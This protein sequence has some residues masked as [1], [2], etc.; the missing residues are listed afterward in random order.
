MQAINSIFANIIRFQKF[1]PGVE[2]P[3]SAIPSLSFP[4]T[5]KPPI[6]PHH[7]NWSITLLD[8][9]QI[10]GHACKD[11]T[12][13]STYGRE[14]LVPRL[15]LLYPRDLPASQWQ[16]NKDDCS[17]ICRLQCTYTIPLSDRNPRLFVMLGS[18][19]LNTYRV[20]PGAVFHSIHTL[21]M[22]RTRSTIFQT[23][24]ANMLPKPNPIVQSF[25]DLVVLIIFTIQN[26]QT[27]NKN[28]SITIDERFRLLLPIQYTLFLG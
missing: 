23:A 12:S 3:D 26:N 6:C 1:Y 7:S 15:Y 18:I 28:D 11:N 20:P 17:K 19:N 24:T 16:Q 4:I 21:V 27:I 22:R 8:S 9:D 25:L 2:E 10:P 14:T 13:Y 5:T